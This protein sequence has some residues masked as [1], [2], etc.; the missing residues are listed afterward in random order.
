[1]VTPN[2]VVHF[3][4]P[5]DD[6]ARAKKFY[7][8]SFAWKIEEYPGMGYYGVGT[9]PVNDKQEPTETGGINGGLGKREGPLAHPVF[10]IGV[11]DIE[12]ALAAV[13]K[14]GGKTVQ[15]KQAVGDMGFTAY[16]RDPEGNVV[17]LWQNSR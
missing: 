4:I 8:K 5:A 6:P 2:K 3:E 13:N 14:N 1:M 11:P 9:V 10:T 17:G 16:F 7:E 12:R 15:P